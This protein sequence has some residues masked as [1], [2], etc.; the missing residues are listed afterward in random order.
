MKLRAAVK[1][2]K[3]IERQHADLEAQ[4]SALQAQVL[5]SVPAQVFPFSWS[6]SCSA[7]V[8]TAHLAS[9]SQIL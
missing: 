7:G 6:P 2:G 1:K 8:P 5:H 4:L 9:E 3:A